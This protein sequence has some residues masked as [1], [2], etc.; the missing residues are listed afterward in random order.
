MDKCPSHFTKEVIDML[1]AASVRIVTFAP[2]T[3]H[4]FQLLDWTLFDSFKRVG[5]YQLLFPDVNSMSRFIDRTE[6]TSRRF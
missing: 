2:H 6:W 1:A 3:T 4:V 5:K